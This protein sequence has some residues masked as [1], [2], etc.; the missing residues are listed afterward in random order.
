[1]PRETKI[2]VVYLNDAD[3]ADTVADSIVQNNVGAVDSVTPAYSDGFGN[4]VQV[5]ERTQR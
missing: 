4:I 3:D 5:P 2:L 1:M